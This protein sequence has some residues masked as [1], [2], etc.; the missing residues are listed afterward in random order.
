MKINNQSSL[1]SIKSEFHR[2]YPYLKLEFYHHTH[3]DHQ[4]SPKSDLITSD[5]KLG[6]LVGNE[7][8]IDFHI[9]PSMTVSEFETEFF[10]LTGLG[11]QVFRN[12]NGVWLQTSSTDSW[13]LEKQNGKGERSEVDYDIE[14]VDISDFDVD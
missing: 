2:L 4:V 1:Q 5:A 8:N 9:V 3:K 7:V 14:P 10:A 11:V 12:S 6:D 13:T